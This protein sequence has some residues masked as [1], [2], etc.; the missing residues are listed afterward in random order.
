VLVQRR[1]ANLP[2]RPGVVVERV[3]ITDGSAFLEL[4]NR[5]HVTGIVA[6]AAAFGAHGPIENARRETQGLLGV[7]AAAQE[8]G[9]P[10]VGTASTIGVYG[11]A[12]GHS[13][14]HEDALLPMAAVH[15]IPAF[16]KVG[17]LLTDYVGGATGIEILSYRIAAVWGPGGRPASPFFAAPHLVHSA[18]HGTTPPPTYAANGIDAPYA[19]DC[20]R[21]LALLTTAPRLRHRVYNIGTGHAVTN[22]QVA[23]AIDKVVPEAGIDLIA[24]RDPN[25]PAEDTYLDITR[26]REDTGY[27]P[28]YD[29][30][31]AVAD[32]VG[33]LRAGN[34]R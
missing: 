26:L 10:R 12:A 14:F 30:E 7:L 17:E 13:P 34:E 29:T 22:A 4:G 20:G 16:K 11:G 3:D 23:A 9:V 31:R 24:G 18:V 21:A 8:W 15:P 6:L 1:A 33:W 2:D 19:R 25:G 32:Y 5:H 27:C 28:C